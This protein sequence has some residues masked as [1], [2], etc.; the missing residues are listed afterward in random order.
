MSIL[1]VNDDEFTVLAV[2]GNSTL[3]G[4]DFNERMVAHF[5]KLYKNKHG[6]DAGKSSRARGKLR[7]EVEQAKVSL[8]F[9][10]QANIDI[11]AFHGG[12]DYSDIITRAEFEDINKV[13][14]S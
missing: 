5:L 1:K 4:E 9:R 7:R 3:G 14:F 6:Q 8:S 12:K 11:E 13:I 10:Y 2:K